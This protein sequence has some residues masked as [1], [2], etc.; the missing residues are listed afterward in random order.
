MGL[1]H[2]MRLLL[3]HNALIFIFRDASVQQ[4]D[5]DIDRHR[6]TS[7]STRQE[8]KGFRK[9]HAVSQR[10]TPEAQL[11]GVGLSLQL[12]LSGNLF[13]PLDGPAAVLVLDAEVQGLPGGLLLLGEL[14]LLL[15][16]LSLVLVLLTLILLPLSSVGYLGLG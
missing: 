15:V 12:L 6:S 11:V 14:S 13:G 16:H 4:D 8:R 10:R 2:C 1:V 5:I 9:A 7:T 3:Q